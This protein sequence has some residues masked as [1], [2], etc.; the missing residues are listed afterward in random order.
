MHKSI[1]LYKEAGSFNSRAATSKNT[2]LL[3]LLQRIS[4][5]EGEEGSSKTIF[6]YEVFFFFHFQPLFP[7]KLQLLFSQV[8]TH[9]HYSDLGTLY[10]PK[11]P[12]F[13]IMLCTC[14]LVLVLFA[15][16]WFSSITSVFVLDW[17]VSCIHQQS[18]LDIIT[19]P[20]PSRRQ[21]VVAITRAAYRYMDEHI[22]C[23]YASSHTLGL[24]DSV[25]IP[26]DSLRVAAPG[27]E[28]GTPCM[29]PENA[30]D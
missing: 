3:S 2:R 21:V 11:R 28:P 14:V 5:M 7:F 26:D 13:I 8:D 24:Q 25:K 15:L 30:T 10:T 19:S 18:Q 17:P 23:R 16:G 12:D 22:A 20:S 1:N 6:N 29:G 27:F 9:L 4:I